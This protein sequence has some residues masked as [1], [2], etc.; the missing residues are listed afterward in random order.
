M[1]DRVAHVLLDRA[2]DVRAVV[3]MDDPR[4]VDHLVGHG[5]LGRALRD[6]DAVAVDRRQHRAEEP[7]RDAAVVERE[8]LELVER[9]RPEGA[10]A[11]D[12][13]RAR[14]A[15]RGELGDA[16]VRRLDDE[17]AVAEDA[18][19]PLVA[20]E[21]LLFLLALV[22]ALLLGRA[23]HEFLG[24]ERLARALILGPVARDAAHVV[25][26]P[27]TVEA[28]VAPR[29]AWRA[30]FRVLVERCGRLGGSGPLRA[31]RRAGPSADPLR[32]RA[33]RD[34]ARDREHGAASRFRLHRTRPSP[35]LDLP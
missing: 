34:E 17:R 35:H 18:R 20:Q 31:R 11:R 21:G 14:L 22:A 1:T 26:A 15:G 4:V 12:G 32:R 16:A 28:R 7:A 25:D 30:P 24:R 6:P 19:A 29:G 3:E 8:V 13:L 10:D 5:H 9:S 2:V 33:R 27:L 23:L